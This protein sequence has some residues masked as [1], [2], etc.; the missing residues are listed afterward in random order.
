MAVQA[1]PNTNPFGTL[2][3][4]PQMSIGRVGTT[5][6][7]QYGISS[8]PVRCSLLILKFMSL[9]A[10]NLQNNANNT[11]PYVVSLASMH[12]VPV[13]NTCQLSANTPL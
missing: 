1:A 3:A 8:M 10:E 12:M 9:I 13:K 11:P 6:S 7:I 5:P 2:P 4:L